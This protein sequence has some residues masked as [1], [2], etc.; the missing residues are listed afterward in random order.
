MSLYYN[1]VQITALKVLKKIG[2]NDA[3]YYEGIFTETGEQL[4]VDEEV[5]QLTRSS[6]IYINM[7]D[8]PTE[9]HL[10]TTISSPQSHFLQNQNSPSSPSV[11]YEPL[12]LR[13]I[14]LGDVQIL[15]SVVLT[16][17]E[18]SSS[19]VVIKKEHIRN[20]TLDLSAL[21]RNVVEKLNGNLNLEAS[22]KDVVLKVLAKDIFNINSS[23]KREKLK[24]LALSLSLM[25]RQFIDHDMTGKIRGEGYESVF[26]SL[27]TKVQNLR[28][29]NPKIDLASPKQL[30]RKKNRVDFVFQEDED[31][32]NALMSNFSEDMDV[33]VV[34]NSLKNTFKYQ[35]CD[36]NS[37]VRANM[38]DLTVAYNLIC[39]RWKPLLVSTDVSERFTFF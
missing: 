12:S 3:S 1:I 37:I 14:D 21:P 19:V 15:N 5:L 31:R 23:I 16:S 4:T 29:T 7:D 34:K 24:E 10:M 27:E 9:S 22:D 26:H 39:D 8:V 18:Q 25:Y 28:R 11:V 36:I 17:E 6:I 38:K 30:L 13:E 35:R 32:R 20:Y 2:I 33:E